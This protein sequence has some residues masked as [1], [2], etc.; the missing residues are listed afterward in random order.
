MRL[1]FQFLYAFNIVPMKHMAAA[2]LT[3][4]PP[5]CTECPYMADSAV[6]AAKVRTP[7]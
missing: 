3:K 2:E 1:D 4:Q 7:V 5:D 6:L